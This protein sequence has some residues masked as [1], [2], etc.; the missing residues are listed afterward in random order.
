MKTFI[1]ELSE[2][3][4]AFEDDLSKETFLG[5]LR[6]G[7]EF[8]EKN[9]MKMVQFYDEIAKEENAQ[10]KVI[11]GKE[12]FQFPERFQSGT[13]MVD[14]GSYDGRDS[15]YFSE[16][17][18]GEYSTIYAF[19][20]DPQN[21][22]NCEER[23]KQ[24]RAKVIV[25]GLSDRTGDQDFVIAD[26]TKRWVAYA[27]TS[28]TT[29]PSE[30]VVIEKVHFVSLDDVVQET[31]GFIKVQAMGNEYSVLCGAEK[32]IKRDHPNLAVVMHSNINDMITIM[33]YLIKIVPEYRFVLRQCVEVVKKRPGRCILSATVSGT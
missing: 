10:N 20:P 18:H 33:G 21:A 12:Y 13:A 2:I 23:L 24:L 22:K 30:K 3:Y 14:C 26:E 19:E 17:C 16:W 8:T 25:A 11:R 9:R 1:A 29:W 6:L 31:V 28:T 4:K 27:V 15:I 7:L 32:I 5:R